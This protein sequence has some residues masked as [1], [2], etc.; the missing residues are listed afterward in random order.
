MRPSRLHLCMN[1]RVAMCPTCSMLLRQVALEG[2]VHLCRLL[3]RA[4]R[5]CRQH[6]ITVLSQGSAACMKHVDA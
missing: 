6:P 4:Q 2:R 3:V 5:L 1:P